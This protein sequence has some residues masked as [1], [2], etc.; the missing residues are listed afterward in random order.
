MRDS[1]DDRRRESEYQNVY[2]LGV[3]AVATLVP[4]PVTLQY[5]MENASVLLRDATERVMKA[6]RVSIK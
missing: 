5:A 6:S 1:A 4:G 2:G 3:D